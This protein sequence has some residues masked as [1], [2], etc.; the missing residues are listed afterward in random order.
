MNCDFAAARPNQKWLTYITYIEMK[1]GRFLYLSAIIDLHS[2]K[3]LSWIIA[4]HMKTELV[5]DTL[6]K[7]IRNRRGVVSEKILFHNDRG[8]S[9]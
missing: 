8:F 9:R 6:E 5:I 3:I 2:R 1:N 4:P 7:A